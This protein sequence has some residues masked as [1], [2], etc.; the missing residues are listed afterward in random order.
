[1]ASPPVHEIERKFLVP[2][3]PADL[4]VH[5]HAVLR[6]GYLTTTSDDAEV[7]LRHADDRYVLTVKRGAGLVRREVEVAL[8]SHQFDALWP[9][10]EGCRVEKVR[11]R[12]PCAGHTAEVDVYRGSLSGLVVAEVEF[13]SEG[14]SRSFQPPSWFG[15]DVTHDARYK[16]RQ[17]AVHGRPAP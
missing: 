9:L 12:V 10:T 13:A 1:M 17:L 14:E 3:P 2:A 5:P 6:Q 15:R 8:T 11:Y 16:N 4:A 7:R